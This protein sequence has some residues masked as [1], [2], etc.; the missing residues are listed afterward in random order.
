M[1]VRDKAIGIIDSLSD[2]QL[3]YFI[4]LFGSF[5][6]GN[7][8]TGINRASYLELKK[9]VRPITDTYNEKAENEEI[10]IKR[11]ALEYIRE[12]RRSVPD[13]TDYDKELAEYRDERFGS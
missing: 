7:L 9:T 13:D 2:E 12:V 8:E 6:D 11:E 10:R 5:I 4:K 3:D 1:S